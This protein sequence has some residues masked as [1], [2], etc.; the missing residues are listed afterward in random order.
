MKMIIIITTIIN[1]SPKM[2][3]RFKAS[4]APANT[5]RM[6]PPLLGR[7]ASGEW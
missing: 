5:W 1:N 3:S 4:H 6:L 2:V 7:V